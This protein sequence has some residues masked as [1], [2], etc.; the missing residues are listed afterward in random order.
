MNCH[1]CRYREVANAGTVHSKCVHPSI[2]DLA[3][4]SL[5]KLFSIF[6][7]VDRVPSIMFSPKVLDSMEKLGITVDVTGFRNNWVNWPFDFDPVWILTCEGFA[8]IRNGNKVPV[9]VRPK[10]GNGAVKQRGS[11]QSKERKGRQR[12][13]SETS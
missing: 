9:R 11:N 12:A 6:A 13:S 3:S 7:S 4:D 5:L 1:E 2:G 8:E 10:N